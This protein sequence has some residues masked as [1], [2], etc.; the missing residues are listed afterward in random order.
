MRRVLS[1]GLIAGIVLTGIVS[2]TG[3][4]HRHYTKPGH[5]SAARHRA[6]MRTYTVR[7]RTYHPTY[8]SVGDTMSGI[9]SW[10]GP[11]FHGKATSNGER[12]NMNAMTAAH[13][14]WPMDTMVRVQ[15]L[16]NGRSAVVRINDRGPFVKGRVIDCSYAAGKKL[17][18]DRT[19][20]AR[21]KL[22]VLGFA[23]KVY[24]PTEA[25][26]A[27]KAPAPR[28]LLSNFGVQVGAFRRYEGARI[29][30]RRYAATVDRPE[31][32]QIRKF[33]VDGAPLYRVWVMGFGSE[34]EARDYIRDQGID[35]GFLIRN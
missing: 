13:K 28:V 27:R 4:S 26:K 21:V 17:G 8:V 1:F 22:T 14:T 2:F 34:E 25:Q 24:R 11:N 10:Y 33:I 15:N 31:R 20:T 12:Y 6:T 3:C 7:G 32:V 9:A 23:G 19:G 30:Q 5:T 29:Y 16:D 35:G 18:L